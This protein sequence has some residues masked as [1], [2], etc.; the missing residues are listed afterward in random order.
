MPE[1]GGEFH[2]HSL[3]KRMNK[4]ITEADWMDRHGRYLL[5]Q[6]RGD[7]SLVLLMY[8]HSVVPQMNQ[9]QVSKF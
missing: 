9:F 4:T 6:L 5:L 7:H 1:K 8:K 2:L 3:E